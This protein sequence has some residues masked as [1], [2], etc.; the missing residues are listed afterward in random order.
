MESTAILPPLTTLIKGE[1]QHF[2]KGLLISKIIHG[3]WL[4][5]PSAYI[6][7]KGKNEL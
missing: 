7:K 2:L 4:N 3:G 5:K 1:L 6:L